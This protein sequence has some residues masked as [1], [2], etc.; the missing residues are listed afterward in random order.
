[1]EIFTIQCK[2]VILTRAINKIISNTFIDT[3]KLG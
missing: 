1:M 2:V 3:V